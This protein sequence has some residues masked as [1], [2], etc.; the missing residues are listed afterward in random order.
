MTYPEVGATGG[1]APPGYVAEHLSVRLGS[2]SQT[3]QRGASAL[4]DWAAQ[5]GAGIQLTPRSPEIAQGGCVLMLVS[6]MGG[7]VI[8]TARIVYV[9]DETDRFGFAYGTLP[10][11]P[12]RGE[13]AFVVNR[14]AEGNV[15]FTIDVFSRPNHLLTRLG[16]PLSRLVQKSTTRRYMRAMQEAV[17]AG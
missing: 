13:E 9:V 2:G 17:R 14:D 8:A 6:L 12:V 7:Y 3:F 5:R 15:T 1:A 16:R 4:R 11:H 10:L